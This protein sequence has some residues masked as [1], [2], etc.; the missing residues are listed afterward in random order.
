[1][2]EGD[3]D[4]ELIH[5]EEQKKLRGAKMTEYLLK[6]LLGEKG[7]GIKHCSMCFGKT[8]FGT[9]GKVYEG[10]FSAQRTNDDMVWFANLCEDCQVKVRDFINE[11]KTDDATGVRE[12]YKDPMGW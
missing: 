1:M 6:Y 3:S 11:N 7:E 2:R 4:Y 10:R 5:S 9:M 8:S 12:Y